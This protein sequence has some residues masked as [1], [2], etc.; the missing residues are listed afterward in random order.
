[1]PKKLRKYWERFNSVIIVYVFLI[2][3]LT[4]VSI[5]FPV[6]RSPRN[7][8]NVLIQITP[9]AIIAI[10]QTIALIGGG[11]DLTVGVVA[12]FTT[13]LAGNFMGQSPFGVFI[14]IIFIFLIA[15]V[16]GTVNGVICNET[17]IPPLI[18]TLATGSI[19][20]GI[21][22]SYR[23]SP[24]GSVPRAIVH[25][26]NIE[27]SIFSIATV[28]LILLYVIFTLIMSRTKFGISV[29]A[30]GGNPEFARMAGISVKKVRIMTYIISAVLA[31][32]AGLVISARTG[33]G[34]PN[35]GDP[36][37]MDSLTAVIIGGATFAGGQGFIVGSFAGAVI[38][39]IIHNVLNISN[40]SP[41]Y[42]YIAKGA[43]LLIAMILNSRKKKL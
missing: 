6:F 30:M 18:V 2:V 7:L 24:G 21:I 23:M 39:S 5:V 34:I 19:I 36:F 32:V 14:T 16:I 11:V 10:G 42:Q 20:R 38:V 17:K 41:F 37:L 31:A 9:L 13:V 26:F 43:V 27:F 28:V 3:V 33:T 40:V 12:S 25:F 15:I 1:V 22:L 35:V 29:Y 8:S 4:A